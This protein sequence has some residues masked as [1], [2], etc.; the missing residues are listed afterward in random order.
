MAQALAFPFFNI[1]QKSKEK[2]RPISH[3]DMELVKNL[4]TTKSELA[5]LHSRFDQITDEVLVDALIFE[6]K[7]LELKYTYYHK[8]LKTKGIVYGE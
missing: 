2:I 4:E 1:F 3:E 8:Q 6:R 7:A 5:K